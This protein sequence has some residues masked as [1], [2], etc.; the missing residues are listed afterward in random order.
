MDC[1][2]YDNFKGLTGVEM[3]PER[4][5]VTLWKCQQPGMVGRD[6][7]GPPV[8]PAPGRDSPTPMPSLAW[9]TARDP[10][11]PWGIPAQPL[12]TLPAEIPSQNPTQPCP[13]HVQD[14]PNHGRC[15][16]FCLLLPRTSQTQFQETGM[17]RASSALLPLPPLKNLYRRKGLGGFASPP[18][19]QSL[20]FQIPAAPGRDFPWSQL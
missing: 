14:T 15:S 11:H 8:P 2:L 19:E 13:G 9:D 7:K 6:I 17:P 18:A 1:A 3:S 20:E 4:V 5:G 10:G 12:A 16:L